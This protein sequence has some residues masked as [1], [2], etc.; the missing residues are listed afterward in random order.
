MEYSCKI[1]GNEKGNQFYNVREMQFGTRDTFIYCQCSSCSCLQL[2]NPPANLSTYYPAQ[3]FSFQLPKENYIKK[4]L[5]I[6]RDRYSFGIPSFVGKIVFSKYGTPTYITWLNEMN[7][8]LS[9][10]ILDVGSG[11]GKLLYRMGNAGFQNLTGIDAFIEKDIQYSNGVQ[12]LKKSLSETNEKFDLIMMHHSLEH[13]EDQH[14]VFK[15]LATML[16]PGKYLFIRIPICTS[17]AWEYYKE[18]WFALEAPRHFFNHSL[19]SL[20]YL[21]EQY[22]FVI[23]KT[24]YDSR[25][26]QLYGSEQYRQDIPLMDERS[27][28]VNPENS[29]FTQLQ[30]EEFEKETKRLNENMRGDQ[31]G[32]FLLKQ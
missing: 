27:Y 32:F 26:I 13:M 30:L 17:Y 22:G 28:F 4:K 20:H 6:Y 5:N 14:A 8:T 29:I 24:I 19:K 23:K 21:A 3:Y 2:T 7:V 11:I 31:A 25:S 10:R 15:K 9:S 12:I 18:N 16:Y 1:C